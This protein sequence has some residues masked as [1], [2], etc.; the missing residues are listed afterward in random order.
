MFLVEQGAAQST[1][2]WPDYYNDIR[3]TESWAYYKVPPPYRTED[4]CIRSNVIFVT[5]FGPITCFLDRIGPKKTIV[6]SQ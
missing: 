3:D 4:K 6:W 1:I 2:S 5:F